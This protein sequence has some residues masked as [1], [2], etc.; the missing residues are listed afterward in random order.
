[1]EDF[2]RKA[3]EIQSSLQALSL[4]FK[5]EETKRLT[6]KLLVGKLLSTRT[7][8]R[9]IV[10]RIT[11]GAWQTKRK[12][13]V[14]DIGDNVF[15]FIFELKEDKELAFNKRL[16]FFN[17]AL[18]V[19]RDWNGDVPI[20]EVRFDSTAFH[21]Q[22]HGLP[23]RLLHAGNAEK[24]GSKIGRVFKES[25]NK[26]AV[27]GGSYLRLRVEIP[28]DVPLQAGFFYKRD[29]GGELWVHFKYER[30]QDFCYSCGMLN[31][32]TGRCT[33]DTPATVTAASGVSAKLYGSWVRAGNKEFLRFLNPP[34]PD[35]GDTRS[36]DTPTEKFQILEDGEKESVISLEKSLVMDLYKDE[37]SQSMVP[38]EETNDLL[39][40]SS[41]RVEDLGA[42][43]C[44]DC[45]SSKPWKD[46]R[47]DILLSLTNSSPVLCALRMSLQGHFADYAEQVQKSFFQYAVKLEKWATIALQKLSFI[48]AQN[49]TQTFNKGR[50]F[51]SPPNGTKAGSPIHS[52]STLRKRIGHFQSPPNKKSRLLDPNM[53]YPSSGKVVTTPIVNAATHKPKMSSGID[54]MT[55]DDPQTFSVGSTRGRRTR[56]WKKDARNHG[57]QVS[58]F[59]NTSHPLMIVDQAT[60]VVGFEEQPH[61]EK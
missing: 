59:S 48:K 24:I 40:S 37:P 21:V 42:M 44:G 19:L 46:D 52:P 5:D 51:L 49:E 47:L 29:N 28:L 8:H 20:Q 15:K 10:S 26:R 39:R 57:R 18:L 3:E 34:A 17:G 35:L 43:L 45:A 11:E 41:L 50:G 36:T 14:L 27:V 23:P 38:F 7:F 22:I 32:V 4:D 31:H 56:S 58:L 6:D 30:L 61:H 25:I 54:Q 9:G 16:W 60:T 53:Q 13:K 33:F 55:K 12:V 1:M 2:Q